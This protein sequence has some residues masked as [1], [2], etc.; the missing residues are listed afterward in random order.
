MECYIRSLTGSEI[1]KLDGQ[2]AE[3]IMHG[4]TADISPWAEFTWYDEAVQE[5]AKPKGKDL[6]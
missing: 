5:Q 3:T 2:V 4:E 1:L 6:C